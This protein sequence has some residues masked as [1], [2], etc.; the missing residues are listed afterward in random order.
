MIKIFKIMDTL[1]LSRNFTNADNRPNDGIL[2]FIYDNANV[3]NL[4]NAA[5]LSNSCVT[6]STDNEGGTS[7]DTNISIVMSAFNPEYADFIK[8]VQK[9]IDTQKVWKDGKT[10]ELL[11]MEKYS[12]ELNRYKFFYI[13]IRPFREKGWFSDKWKFNIDEKFKI[14]EIDKI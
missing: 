6:K 3:Q 9:V 10:Y 12:P 2:Q 14:I 1:I 7:N 8:R 13:K 5:N 4:S 11:V